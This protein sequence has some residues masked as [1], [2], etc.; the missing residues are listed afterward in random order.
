ML[1]VKDQ[2]HP[3]DSKNVTVVNRVRRG[4]SVNG[5]SSSAFS[6]AQLQQIV[7]AELDAQVLL[8]PRGERLQISHAN[9]AAEALL[10]R[11]DEFPE[12]RAVA[13]TCRSVWVDGRAVNLMNVMWPGGHRWYDVRIRR[14]YGRVSVTF[15]DV[16]K[17]HDSQDALIDS[18]GR[19]RLLA[20]NA[21]DLVFQVKGKRLEWVSTSVRDLLGWDQTEVIGQ[22]VIDLVH[23]E[24][25]RK[26]QEAC[27]VV[28]Q[29]QRFDARFRHSNGSW[30]WVSVLMRPA[31]ELGGGVARIGS[32]RSLADQ[33]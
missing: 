32:C 23:P 16:T 22:R 29:A 19:Y 14:L 13:A 28:G 31:Q 2:R 5:S 3:A 9:K 33:H 6:E 1:A 10:G 24:D 15:V 12:L 20:E 25:R 21:G 17:R 7:D 30:V 26:V 8:L 4:V 27:D 11:V 18:Q